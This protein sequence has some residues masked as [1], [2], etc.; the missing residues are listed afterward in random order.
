MKKTFIIIAFAIL[1][2]TL[3]LNTGCE[4]DPEETCQQD[5]FCDGTVSV[6]AC[7]TD[8]EDC[9]YSYK[10]KKYPDTEQGLADLIDALDCTTAK[11]S[12]SFEEQKAFLVARLKYLIED[13]RIKSRQE[14]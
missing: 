5:M 13:A 2:G 10:G 14:K 12:A 8:G 11:K 7:C 1:G 6:T 9:Y 4:L 3:A